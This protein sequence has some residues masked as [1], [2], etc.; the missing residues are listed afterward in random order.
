MQ[1]T[2]LTVWTKAGSDVPQGK[3]LACVFT[4]ARNLCYMRFREQK[5]KSDVALEDLAEK[6]DVY[7]RQH[8]VCVGSY[9]GTL[10]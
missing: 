9:S 3:P 4:I 1:E 6:E 5:M 8:H 10:P 7:K 2:Y